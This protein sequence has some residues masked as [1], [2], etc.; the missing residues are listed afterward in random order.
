MLNVS[1]M[2]VCS[3]GSMHDTR[4]PRRR[5]RGA[6]L[7]LASGAQVGSQSLYQCVLVGIGLTARCARAA[8][9]SEKNR[10][11]ELYEA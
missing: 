2:A 5:H 9:A 11:V 4:I 8:Q 7:L 1:Q 3:R 10:V 6:S